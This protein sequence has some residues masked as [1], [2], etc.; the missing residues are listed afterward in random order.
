MSTLFLAFDHIF[1]HSWTY[2][3]HWKINVNKVRGILLCHMQV[4]PASWPTYYVTG[5]HSG[6]KLKVRGIGKRKN[7]IGLRPWFQLWTHEGGTG[8]PV[9]SNQTGGYW[10][11]LKAKIARRHRESFIISENHLDWGHYRANNNWLG[12]LRLRP[13][14]FRYNGCQGI[15]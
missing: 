13:W 1:G 8:P 11:F 15:E 10:K 4:R 5:H 9:T 14:R 2:Q 6:W 7:Q 12:N 3:R